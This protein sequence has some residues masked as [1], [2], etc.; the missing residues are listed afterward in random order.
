MEVLTMDH[1]ISKLLEN[2]LSQGLSL[3]F[4]VVGILYLYGKIKECEADRK[5]LWEKLLAFTQ[6]QN[7]P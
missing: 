5:Q 7:R 2:I 1:F 6:N 3:T 4:S